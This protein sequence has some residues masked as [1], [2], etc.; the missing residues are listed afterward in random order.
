MFSLL[1]A[2]TGLLV[3]SQPPA[4]AAHAVQPSAA[5]VARSASS[6]VDP[7]S[8]NSIF[9]SSLLA[10]EPQVS[11]AKAKIEAAKGIPMWAS[12]CH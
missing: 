8:L 2:P 3:P 11:K 7:R 9:P 12:N 6:M 10:D 1:V 5:Y 4:L